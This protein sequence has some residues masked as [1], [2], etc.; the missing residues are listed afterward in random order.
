M[1]HSALNQSLL[2]YLRYQYPAMR[3]DILLNKRVQDLE[4]TV[5]S[6]GPLIESF[7]L[8]RDQLKAELAQARAHNAALLE[9]CEAALI[10]IDRAGET[11]RL[12]LG[13]L[14]RYR[15]IEAAIALE[16]GEKSS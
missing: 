8:E 7:E 3:G 5:A 9:A 13:M 16:K 14:P 10:I 1:S 6:A 11:A 2:E 12:P 4:S 15:Q